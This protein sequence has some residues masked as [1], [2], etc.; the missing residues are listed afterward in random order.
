MVGSRR[1][2][3][4]HSRRHRHPEQMATAH[5]ANMRPWPAFTP[6]SPAPSSLPFSGGTRGCRSGPTHDRARV[7][8]RGRG[9]GSHRQPG[10]HP[11]GERGG[12][13]GRGATRG[14]GLLR[15]GWIADFLPLPVID[16]SWPVSGSRSWSSSSLPSS[17]CRWRHDDDRPGPGRRRPVR[18][19][20]RLALAIACGVLAIVVAGEKLD[21]RIPVPS[22]VS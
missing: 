1:G 11:P 6:S 13:D 19:A 2:G 8:R 16:G 22:S 9:G 3:R 14:A 10:L 20:Q 21:H 4:P 15:L 7:R 18:P 5:L 17:G 12:P